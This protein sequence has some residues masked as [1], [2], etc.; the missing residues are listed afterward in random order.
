MDSIS[1]ELNRPISALVDEE[2]EQ[3][4]RL[5][6]RT[7]PT[8]GKHLF[9][10]SLAVDSPELLVR[11]LTIKPDFDCSGFAIRTHCAVTS[12]YYEELCRRGILVPTG[13]FTSIGDVDFPVAHFVWAK[14]T[15]NFKCSQCDRVS[16]SSQCYFDEHD[17]TCLCMACEALLGGDI[18]PDFDFDDGSLDELDNL[19]F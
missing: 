17:G 18:E 6:V 2:A 8:A 11:R 15:D 12:Q 7:T 16:P 13:E 14:C 19:D 3:C 10:E 9:A 5:V 1:Y 4:S